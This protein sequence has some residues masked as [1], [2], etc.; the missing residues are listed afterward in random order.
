M[1][2]TDLVTW[3]I[4]RESRFLITCGLCSATKGCTGIIR[5]KKTRESEY[6][7]HI[8]KPNW[9]FN[10]VLGCLS[11]QR[12]PYEWQKS[13]VGWNFH[14]S[15]FWNISVNSPREP[16]SLGRYICISFPCCLHELKF[17]SIIVSCIV[18]SGKPVK[19]RKHLISNLSERVKQ[20][21]QYL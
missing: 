13:C 5:R 20:H 11:S 9:D 6:I 15:I 4:K 10:R 3:M 16:S 19:W 8:C 12:M 14:S 7:S 17:A 1:E 18:V 21:L 2:Q